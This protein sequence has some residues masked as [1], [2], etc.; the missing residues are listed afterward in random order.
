MEVGPLVLM[1]LHLIIYQTVFKIYNMK[2]IL[3]FIFTFFSFS[4]FFGQGNN[5]QFNQVINQDFTVTA[6]TGWTE[7][8]LSSGTIIVPSNTVWKITSSSAFSASASSHIGYKDY[9][10]GIMIGKQVAH[11]RI[12]GMLPHPIWLSSG[13]YTVWLSNN[14]SSYPIIFGSISAIEFNIVQ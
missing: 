10:A 6:P 2:K 1:P 9:S 7:S 13:T 11:D 5:L 8:W 12:K 3:P 4:Y 14:N